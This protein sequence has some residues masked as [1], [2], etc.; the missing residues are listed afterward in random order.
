MYFPITDLFFIRDTEAGYALVPAKPITFLDKVKAFFGFNRTEVDPLSNARPPYNPS[1]ITTEPSI[2]KPKF[3]EVEY[4]PDK[5]PP[6]QHSTTPSYKGKGK[7]KGK[8]SKTFRS[9]NGEI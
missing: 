5:P 8:N 1:M 3:N 9:A 7:G 2:Y 4:L 6:E